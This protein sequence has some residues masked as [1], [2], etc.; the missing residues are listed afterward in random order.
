MVAIGALP[1]SF[2]AALAP[3]YSW[4]ARAGYRVVHV[5]QEGKPAGHQRPSYEVD[6][7]QEAVRDDSAVPAGGDEDASADHVG[8]DDGREEKQYR[9]RE[10][11]LLAVRVRTPFEQ[12]HH[13]G[14]GA[15]DGA[16]NDGAASRGYCDCKLNRGLA[17]DFVHGER[18]RDG[19]ANSHR[20]AQRNG[21]G[22]GDE[23]T[24]H[25]RHAYGQRAMSARTV[26]YIVDWY[27][28]QQNV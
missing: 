18:E 26:V 20:H 16:G 13:Q 21:E 17:V 11:S 3:D 8:R 4:S 24:V 10:K 6:K 25:Q 9:E 22:E 12:P 2:D 7:E 5:D 23:E 27:H 28:R 19:G 1:V 15:T 14:D